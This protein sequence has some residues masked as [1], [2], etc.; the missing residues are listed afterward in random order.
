VT[1]AT[2]SVPLYGGAVPGLGADADGATNRRQAVGHALQASA[3]S[4]VCEL[5]TCTIVGDAELKVAVRAGHGDRGP[6]GLRVLRNVLQGLQDAEIHGGLGVPRVPPD[7][8]GL[9]EDRQR[10]LAGLGLQRRR[11]SLVGQQRGVDPACQGAQ[12]VERR[13]EPGAELARQLQDAVSVPSV[14]LQQAE[15]DCQRDKLLLRAVVQVPLDPVPLLILC[16][17]QPSA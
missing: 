17:H 3:L 14:V 1:W 7:A 5:K 6:G 10:R 13:M 11:Q 12:V 8:V 2:G 9:D 15:L 4:D 16:V